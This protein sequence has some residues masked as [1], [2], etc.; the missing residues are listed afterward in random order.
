MRGRACRRDS[1]RSPGRRSARAVWRTMS[2]AKSSLVRSPASAIALPPLSVICRTTA[3]AASPFRSTTPTAAPSW[4]KRSAPAR[5]MPEPAAVTIPILFARRMLVSSVVPRR[6]FR[7]CERGWCQWGCAASTL[8]SVIAS[9]AKQS[10]ANVG[11]ISR[12]RLIRSARN[13]RMTA[14]SNR[15]DYAT[16]AVTWPVPAGSN[17]GT[18][19]IIKRPR[20][21]GAAEHGGDGR[22][23]LRQSR[24]MSANAMDNAPMGPIHWRVLSLVAA[25]YFIDVIDYTMFGAMTPDMINSGFLTAPGAA[26]GQQRH[27]DRPVPRRPRPGRVHRP[28]RPQGGLP[29]QPPA[30]RDRD[31]RRRMG[32]Q[33]D[34]AAG[35]SGSSPASGSA[36][37]NRCA[38]PT[39]R[40]TR[41]SKIADASSP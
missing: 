4:A 2:R 26:I 15:H 36:P 28:V 7:S 38:S 24:P 25:G 16:R 20:R 34:L 21:M 13:D 37:S 27:A 19:R 5:P 30:V 14:G 12:G 23:W 3:L 33:P 18:A 22:S 9:E 35:R 8:P 40:N 31:D 17:A 10:P 1:R 32:A 11:A 41:R 39:P 6:R 29:V